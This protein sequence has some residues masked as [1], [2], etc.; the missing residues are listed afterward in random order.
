VRLE[1]VLGVYRIE[2]PFYFLKPRS[3]PFLLKRKRDN[4]KAD[5]NHQLWF[6]VS[7]KED[8]DST[9]HVLEICNETGVPFIHL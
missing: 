2:A 4:I 3:W 7:R 6:Q 1:S 8:K 5:S 9:T